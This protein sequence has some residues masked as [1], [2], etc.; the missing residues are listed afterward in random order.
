[1][2]IIGNQNQTTSSHRSELD[3]IQR[4]YKES[5]RYAIWLWNF[6]YLH[7]N[8]N[9]HNHFPRN[10]NFLFET[11]KSNK[12]LLERI[13]LTQKKLINDK[14]LEF[15]A[16]RRRLLSLLNKELQ[17]LHSKLNLEIT[18]PLQS[19]GITP[20]ELI[21]AQIDLSPINAVAIN[22]FLDEFKIKW[23]TMLR[24]HE[25]Y[26]WFRT[27]SYYEKIQYFSEWLSKQSQTANQHITP[28]DFNDQE[29]IEIVC[30]RSLDHPA[31]IRLFVE[32]FKRAW[33]SKTYREKLAGRKQCNIALSTDALSILNHLSKKHRYSKA[34]ILEI[35]LLGE[36]RHGHYISQ[37]LKEIE[38]LTRPLTLEELSSMSSI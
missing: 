23:H 24:N 10:E 19:Y 34:K 37:K 9:F 14:E 2:K 25:I 5:S 15:I 7:A 17:R 16:S 33:S 36:K 31:D 3:E 30:E 12:A 22:K 11:I 27:D 20:R 29:F 13:C 32:K 4:R 38:F 6:S 26:K 1:M 35:L 28:D 21:V 8:V 18:I